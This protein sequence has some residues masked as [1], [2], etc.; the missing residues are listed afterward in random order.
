MGTPTGNPVTPVLKISSNT[1]VAQK[2]PDIIDTDAG[3][4][5][6]GDASIEQVG[7]QLMDQIIDTASGRYTPMAVRLQQDDFI[8]WKRTVSL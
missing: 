1:A 8:P 5:I 2:M 3:P 6:T 7:E 4:V